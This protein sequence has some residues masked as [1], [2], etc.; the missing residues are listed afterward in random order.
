MINYR[1]TFALSY[2]LGR[3][4]FVGFGFSLLRKLVG[5]DSWLAAILGT[6]LGALIVIILAKL[7]NKID[8]NI[9]DLKTNKFMKYSL[10]IVFLLFN[11]FVFSQMI[12]IFQT[13]ASSFF[14]INSPTFFISLPI[15]FIVYRITKNGFPTIAKIAEIL[16]PISIILFLFSFFGLLQHFKLE[17]F[18]PLITTKPLTL[19]QGTLYFAAYSS[20]SFFLLLNVPM[21]K[22]KLAAKYTF[23]TITVVLLCVFIIGVL[24]PNLIQ[25][26]RYPEYMMLKKIKIFNFIEKV[27]NILSIT[28]LFDLFMA[29]SIAGENIKECLPRKKNNLIFIG[30]LI[31]LYIGAIVS[32]IFYREELMLYHILPIVLGS[33]EIIFLLLLVL[34][35]KK[36]KKEKL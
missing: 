1:K 21:E 16:M 7:K 27:E 9:K 18:K 19:L 13:F 12:F 30:C 32:G 23:S 11:I 5:R 2:F 4:F 14:L 3:I 17:Y 10:L 24:G 26:Y 34:L 29:M 36:R 31:L 33:F 6:L 20:S 22:N 8:T 35:P 15:P 28:W 25:I